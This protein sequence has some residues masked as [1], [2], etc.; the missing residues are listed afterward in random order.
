[1][2]AKLCSI[3]NSKGVRIPQRLIARYQLGN[4]ILLEESEDGIL[5]KPAQSARPLS[6]EATFAEMAQEQE[7]WSDLEATVSDGL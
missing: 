1:M 2:T 5:I 7:D 3:G 4:D 6:W